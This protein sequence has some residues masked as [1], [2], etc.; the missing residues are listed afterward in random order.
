MEGDITMTL[1]RLLTEINAFL[2]NTDSEVERIEVLNTLRQ[3]LHQHS[4]FVDEPVDCVLWVKTSELV[5]NDYN[6]NFMAPSEKNCYN[7]LW[8]LMGIHN[9]LLQQYV[10]KSTSL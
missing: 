7:V 6:P 5:P 8:K 9:P 2:K 10:K 1:E 4:P 3:T